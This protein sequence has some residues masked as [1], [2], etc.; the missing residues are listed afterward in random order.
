MVGVEGL[1]V[2]LPGEIISGQRGADVLRHL[3]AVDPVGVGVAAIIGAVIGDS[4][5]LHDRAPFR[6]AAF[7]TSSASGFPRHFGPGH[8]MLAEKPVQPLGNSKAV[9]FGRFIALLRIS[10]G[11]WP[12]HWNFIAKRFLAANVSGAHLLAGGT[13]AL[14][15]FAGDGRREWLEPVLLGRTGH[16]GGDRSHCGNLAAQ[17]HIWR[18]RRTRNR[19][20]PQ[21]RR[22]RGRPGVRPLRNGFCCVR[23]VERALRA[24]LDAYSRPGRTANAVTARNAL[25]D[26]LIGLGHVSGRCASIRLRAIRWARNAAFRSPTAARMIA[27][28]IR[29]YR[30][31]EVFDVGEPRSDRWAA[32]DVPDMVDM[33]HAD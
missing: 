11:R 21:V 24:A 26:G 28:F 12:A 33:S 6:H 9:F 27:P 30:D 16:R 20:R 32:H 4:I 3:L 31:G 19:A 8:V 5:G 22:N 29:M 18:D 7:R 13:T 15:Y 25:D 2:P 23:G 17:T 10:P 1:G 14:V